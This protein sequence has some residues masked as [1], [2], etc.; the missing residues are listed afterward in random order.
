MRNSA[1]ASFSVWG[2]SGYCGIDPNTGNA[3][4]CQAGQAFYSIEHGKRAGV[5]VLHVS[6]QINGLYTHTHT[7]G[8]RTGGPCCCPTRWRWRCRRTVRRVEALHLLAGWPPPGH[9]APA[10]HAL[11]QGSHQSADAARQ[12]LTPKP[13]ASASAWLTCTPK[14]GQLLSEV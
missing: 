2:I 11:P 7:Q 8:S 14:G 12:G 9:P 10:A 5:P 3:G 1:G 4:V 6:M 13:A